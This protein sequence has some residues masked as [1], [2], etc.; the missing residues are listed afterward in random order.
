MELKGK[1]KQVAAAVLLV[2]VVVTAIAIAAHGNNESQRKKD[3]AEADSLLSSSFNYINAFSFSKAYKNASY[4]LA[5][6]QKIGDS[7]G[8]ANSY[9]SLARTYEEI[10]FWGEAWRCLNLAKAGISSLSPRQKYVYY[11]A[12]VSYA[13]EHKKGFALGEQ[14][15]RQSIENDRKIPDSVYTY[16]DMSNL[17]E[18]YINQGKY[19]EAQNILDPLEKHGDKFFSTQIAYC[20]MLMSKRKGERDS[21]YAYA[22][23][24]LA[25]SKRYKQLNLQLDALQTMTTIDSTRSDMGKFIDHYVAYTNLKDSLNG[26]SSTSRINQVKEKFAIDRQR[27][28]MEEKATRQRTVLLVVLLI[29]VSTAAVLLLLFLRAKERRARAELEASKLSDELRRKE[30]EQELANLKMTQEKEKLAKSQK[31]NMSMSLQLAMVDEGGK[32]KRMKTL[33]KEFNLIDN[34]FS[35][36]L[37]KE[38]PDISRAE[39]RLA[40]LIKQGLDSHEI[41][42]I[43]N[44]SSSGLYKL[45]YRLRKRLGIGE[46]NLEK[47]LRDGRGRLA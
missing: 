22:T 11:Y 6:Y 46:G 13:V 10:E 2:V 32:R 7:E 16:T 3:K 44:I 20:R 36:Q 37:E 40:C 31:E 45:R 35:R 18:V 29:V 21:T 5:L 27:M 8:I 38:Y 12:M 24:C 34:E 4:A 39:E 25:R 30:L 41:L 47:F 15:L 26:T 28:L 17:A 43:L 1:K 23:E 42:G 33:D 14:V 19:D 9:I